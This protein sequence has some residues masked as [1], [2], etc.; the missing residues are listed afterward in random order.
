MHTCAP[1]R[2]FGFLQLFKKKQKNIELK[3]P[4]KHARTCPKSSEKLSLPKY[5]LILQ[6]NSLHF[7]KM[8]RAEQEFTNWAA[9]YLEN[10]QRFP[11]KVVKMSIWEAPVRPPAPSSPTIKRTSFK[12][13]TG[14]VL[15]TRKFP[16]V[17]AFPV[18]KHLPGKT[19]WKL[20]FAEPMFAWSSRLQSSS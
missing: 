6:R 20:D 14:C 17:V 12:K 11:K 18:G 10:D 5:S 8:D 1:E 4:L 3:S 19:G 16:K 15:I 9:Q 7:P 2:F 13:I